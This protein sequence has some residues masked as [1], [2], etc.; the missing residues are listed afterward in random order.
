MHLRAATT[1]MGFDSDYRC[2]LL[3]P[4][5]VSPSLL[6]K[7]RICLFMLVGEDPGCWV[8]KKEIYPDLVSKREIYPDLVSR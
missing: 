5:Q 7:S 4:G 8:S 3:V 6:E 2:T 1:F